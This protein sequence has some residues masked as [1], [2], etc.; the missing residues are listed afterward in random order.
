MANILGGNHENYG[1][2]RG[3]LRPQVISDLAL[4]ELSYS[5]IGEKYGVTKQAVG[6]F[7]QRYKLDVERQRANME[8]KFAG[9]WIADK[10]ARVAEYQNQAEKIAE[11]CEG[12]DWKLS[13]EWIKVLQSALRSAAEELD[14]LR[15]NLNVSGQVSYVVNG[16]NT[17]DLS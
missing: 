2:L 8:D 11:K 13:P 12:V 9:L 7:Y 14:D 3:H 10:M 6:A 5:Q 16:V 1:A 4:G 17:E 15:T